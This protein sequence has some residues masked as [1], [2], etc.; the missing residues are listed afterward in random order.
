M[1]SP[2]ADGDGR[3]LTIEIP[4]RESRRR[5]RPF[6]DCSSRRPVQ[7]AATRS[8]AGESA[9]CPRS[10]QTC[11]PWDGLPAPPRSSLPRPSFWACAASPRRLAVARTAHPGESL[12]RGGRHPCSVE[13][14]QTRNSVA[15]DVRLLAPGDSPTDRCTRMDAA[16]VA[17]PWPTSSNTRAATTGRSTGARAVCACYWFHLLVW[18]ALRGC[19]WK[20]NALATTR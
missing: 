15:P 10:W 5:S 3:R 4:S 19:A 8:P 14:L 18:M 13:V 17:A 16:D 12:S 2:A 20:P 11:R 1:L 6:R 7:P 9:A